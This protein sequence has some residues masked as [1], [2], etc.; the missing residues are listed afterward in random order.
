MC[1]L[2]NLRRSVWL[3]FVSFCQDMLRFPTSCSLGIG[4]APGKHCQNRVNFK[5][6][7]KLKGLQFCQID[8]CRKSN[9]ASHVFHLILTHIWFWLGETQMEPGCSMTHRIMG[10]RLW[11][12]FIDS[13]FHFVDSWVQ[14]LDYRISFSGSRGVNFV[15]KVFRRWG[16]K[17]LWQRECSGV[18]THF[19][20]SKQ[21][22]SELSYMALW[23]A[24]ILCFLRVIAW[25]DTPKYG[26][27]LRDT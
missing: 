27:T 25:M 22:S 17:K 6:F 19:I 12:L 20:C 3:F 1:L 2:P 15:P 7:V 13:G 4:V 24:S 9:W 5:Q 10:P 23:V 21:A 16:P 11:N 14:I 18:P 8:S 26:E